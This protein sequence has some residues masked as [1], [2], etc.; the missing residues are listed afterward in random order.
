MSVF[1]KPNTAPA[2]SA[3][4]AQR[5]AFAA[6]QAP[7]AAPAAAPKAPVSAGRAPTPK[8]T[9]PAFTLSVKAEGSEELQTLTGLF[10][11]T[12]KSGQPVL[13]GSDR[14]TGIRYNAFINKDGTYSLS[15]KGE[16]GKFQKVATLSEKTS[17]GGNVHFYGQGEDGTRYYIF[18]KDRK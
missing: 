14:N 3:P 13:S 9:M 11:D 10:N 18:P 12:T 8:G 17:K 6:K 15:Y 4:A 16:D 1:R 7:A 2:A 5:P